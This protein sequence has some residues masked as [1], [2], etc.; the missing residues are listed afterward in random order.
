MNV[1]ACFTNLSF[2][3]KAPEITLFQPCFFNKNSGAIAW[4][5]IK[6]CGYQWTHK[7]SIE[8]DY[9]YRYFDRFGNFTPI[10]ALNKN[11]N[12]LHEATSAY[13]I[14]ITVKYLN[15]SVGKGVC[16]AVFHKKSLSKII[17]V[18]LLKSNNIIASDLFDGNG[19]LSF[20]LSNSFVICADARVLQGEV[21]HP[22]NLN[23]SLH[24]FSLTD[25]NQLNICMKG[26]GRGSHATAFR[27]DIT[28]DA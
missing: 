4:K 21:I 7:F 13:P 19:A 14:G 20:Q 24:K 5:V 25:K 3:Q 27:F 9:S 1:E 15:N 8:Q 6:N 16:E 18:Q 26:G 17:G 28:H 10:T 2:A 22:N 23:V 12:G 11:E